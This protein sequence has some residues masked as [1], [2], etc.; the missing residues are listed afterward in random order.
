MSGM[1]TL[2]DFWD[3]ILV[4]DKPRK[5]AEYAE[6]DDFVAELSSS[7]HPRIL[8]YICCIVVGVA[9]S[10]SAWMPSQPSSTSERR[11]VYTAAARSDA[12]CTA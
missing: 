6:L 12:A 2:V 8:F 5:R 1:H 11:I 7:K 10:S 4:L 3:G 9:V